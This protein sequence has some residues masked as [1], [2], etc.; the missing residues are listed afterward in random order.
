MIAERCGLSRTE[1]DEFA[2]RSHERAAAAQDDGRFTAQIAPVPAP[3]GTVVELDEGVRRGASAP[4][5]PDRSPTVRL[6]C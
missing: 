4:A 3:D 6:P 5:A 1:L 2:L